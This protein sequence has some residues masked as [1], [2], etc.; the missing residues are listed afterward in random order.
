MQNI[1]Q[2]TYQSLPPGWNRHDH[3]PALSE[4]S[5]S[6][7]AAHTSGATGSLAPRT[8][9]SKVTIASTGISD[10]DLPWP[11]PTPAHLHSPWVGEFYIS[12]YTG[13]LSNKSDSNLDSV[14]ATTAPYTPVRRPVEAPDESWRAQLVVALSSPPRPF[15]VESPSSS[16]YLPQAQD[17]HTLE[18]PPVLPTPGPSRTKVSIRA[19]LSRQHAPTP[20][21]RISPF[22]ASA[23][24]ND[25]DLQDDPF[26]TDILHAFLEIEEEALYAK[27]RLLQR[28][29][30]KGKFRAQYVCS[31]LLIL[32][33]VGP[34]FSQVVLVIVTLQSIPQSFQSP[35]I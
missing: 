20:Y 34:D 14:D 26:S 25:S 12:P 5:L 9:T 3:S 6:Y 27:K 35:L 16:D 19:G 1:S 17:R 30:A 29:L 33:L 2:D 32:F 15:T 18:T 13:G 28:R 21:Q 22:L 7:C 24:N 31:I 8:P 4:G 23:A 10:R 11:A